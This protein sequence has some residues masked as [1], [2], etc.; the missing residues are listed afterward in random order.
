[1]DGKKA[2]DFHVAYGESDLVVRFQRN[3]YAEVEAVYKHPNYYPDHEIVNDIALIKLARPLE[4]TVAVQPACLPDHH[5]RWHYDGALKV[6]PIAC[7]S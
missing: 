2:E 6:R 4:F 5:Y 1:M 7:L 3:Q